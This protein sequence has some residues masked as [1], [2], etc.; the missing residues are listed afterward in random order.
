MHQHEPKIAFHIQ[1]LGHFQH[2]YIHVLKVMPYPSVTEGALDM[3]VVPLDP[4]SLSKDP[5]L[6]SSGFSA[7]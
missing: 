3:R 2:I 4:F 6:S 7:W 1:Y 5:F